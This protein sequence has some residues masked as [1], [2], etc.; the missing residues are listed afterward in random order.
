MSSTLRRTLVEATRQ[1]ARMLLGTFLIAA[2]VAHLLIR[3][4]FLAQVPSW[5]PWPTAVIAISGVIEV[6]LGAAVLV[7]RR[8]RQLVGY[9]VAAWFA[10]IVVGNVHQ[11]VA[12]IDAFGLTTDTARWLRVGLQPVLVAWAW[13]AARRDPQNS[14]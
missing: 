11:A 8:Y 2:G 14:Q 9:A 13:W 7:V 4:E 1:G 10:V 6:V 5:M 3:E 12:G